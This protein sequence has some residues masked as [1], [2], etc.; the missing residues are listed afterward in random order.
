MSIRIPTAIKCKLESLSIQPENI[1]D[2]FLRVQV[3]IGLDKWKVNRRSISQ[4]HSAFDACVLAI[5]GTIIFI[6]LSIISCSPTNAN[7]SQFQLIM[8]KC[9]KPQKLK[10]GVAVSSGGGGRR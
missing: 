1:S 9:S 5:N 7:N 6:N 8:W 10:R 4:N 3:T 2:V